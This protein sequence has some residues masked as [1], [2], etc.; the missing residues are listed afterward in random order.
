VKPGNVIYYRN[1]NDKDDSN[2][3][4]LPGA[5]YLYQH[6]SHFAAEHKRKV[7]LSNGSVKGGKRLFRATAFTFERTNLSKEALSPGGNLVES[8]VTAA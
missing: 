8:A 3:N 5:Y 4:Y 1:V 2:R 7:Y 6:S